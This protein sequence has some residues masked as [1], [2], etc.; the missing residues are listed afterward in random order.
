MRD[1]SVRGLTSNP[2]IFQKAIA[3]S[4]EYDDQFREI[5]A[6]D[7]P[8]IDDY[9]ALVLRD[10]D[11]ASTRCP[12]LPRQRRRDGFV[13]V[14]VDPGLAHDGAGTEAATPTSTSASPAQPDGQD[15]RHRGR[16]RPDPDDDRRRP[17]HQRDVD[18]QA[19]ALRRGDGGVHRR[20]GGLA[21]V[22]GAD[23]SAVA[24][25]ASFFV[26]R[27]DTEVDR[28]LER[29]GRRRRWS[30]GARP[31]SPRASSPTRCSRRRSA[32]H[33]GRP[34]PSGVPRCSG[35]CWAST[36][37]KNPAYPDTLYVDEL[38]RPDTVNTMPDA[39]IEAFAD[40]GTL[41][42]GSTPTSTSPRRVGRLDE[43][44]VDVADVGAAWNAKESAASRRASTSCSTPL[45]PRRPDCAP[46]DDAVHGLDAAPPV[47][48]DVRTAG[49]AG[50]R[51]AARDGERDRRVARELLEAALDLLTDQPGTLDLKIA[52]ATVEE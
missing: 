52:A 51:R 29:S 27:V 1:G 6:D 23:L 32:V 20:A 37:T 42:R 46:V 50:P 19:R 45:R 28:R 43:V 15:P 34:S 26:S 49:A 8:V 39:T 40:H 9:W 22:P 48:P 21:A 33:A 38:I 14:E 41:D 2:T 24:S 7:G 4:S 36:S 25:V 10:I 47:P 44:G 3:G 13:S 30:C 11:S 18:L 17:E 5:S 35:R 31:P 12:G 16:P